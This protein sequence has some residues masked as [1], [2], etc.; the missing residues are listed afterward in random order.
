MDTLLRSLTINRRLVNTETV[1]HSP[2]GGLYGDGLRGV[3]MGAQQT[4]QYAIDLID[5]AIERKLYLEFLFHRIVPNPTESTQFDPDDFE[6][7]CA[8]IAE[9]RDRGLLTVTTPADLYLQ[10]TGEV[11]T[12]EGVDYIRSASATGRTLMLKLPG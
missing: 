6:A 9:K 8:Y 7:V 10:H 11:V 2:V 5:E 12:V 1:K 3:N 4:V